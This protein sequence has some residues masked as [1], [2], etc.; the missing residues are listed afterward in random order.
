M[1][2]FAAAFDEHP[3]ILTDGGIETRVMFDSPLTLPAGVEAA[4][5]LDDPAGREALRSIYDSYVAAA[6]EHGLPLIIGTPTFR[7]SPRWARAAGLD[8]DADVRRLNR[9]A[10]ALHQDVRERGGHAPVY[11]AG[12]IG[13]AGDAY[14]PEDGLP[15]GEA[16]EYHRLQSEALAQ[17][18][19]DLLFAPTFPSVEEALGVA[20]A[21]AATG[22]PYAV[23]YVLG[24]DGRMLD[25][26]TLHDA[27]ERIDAA[28]SPSPLY[29]SL[30]CIHTSLGERALADEAV[31][32]P[33][34]GRR[35]A[36]LKANASPLPTTELVTLD[37]PEGD[38]PEPFAA[39]MWGLKERF[40]LRILGG[41]C[42]TD[43]RHM[44]ALA[45]RMAAAPR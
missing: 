2:D 8:G 41:C 20:A 5:M 9:A 15:A 43:D 28:V 42:G 23:S 31:V 45:Q 19:V 40:G 1:S 17:A 38:A 14:Q 11:I 18:G 25:G 26:T 13:P 6:R 3:L 36:E 16:R 35:L 37:H 29:H 21:M 32:T 27:I 24:S 39:A 7:A 22:L 44:R 10:V 4:G 34:V 30:S 33:L 12:V